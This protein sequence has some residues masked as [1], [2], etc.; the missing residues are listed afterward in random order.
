[1]CRYHA[2]VAEKARRKE[3]AYLLALSAYTPLQ[4]ARKRARCEDEKPCKIGML[5][6]DMLLVILRM[7]FNEAPRETLTDT[8]VEYFSI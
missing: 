7:A 6:S 3:I 8:P 4:R 1:M 2:I 5:S